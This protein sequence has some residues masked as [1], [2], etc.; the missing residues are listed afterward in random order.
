MDADAASNVGESIAVAGE[1]AVDDRRAPRTEDAAATAASGTVIAGERAV[2]HRQRP[3]VEDTTAGVETG[4]AA[5][6]AAD[7]REGPAAMVNAAT[8]AGKV[9]TNGA[10][11]HSQAARLAVNAAPIVVRG[12]TGVAKTVSDGQSSDGDTDGTGDAEH[13]IGGVRVVA[14]DRNPDRQG[15]AVNGQVLVEQ[16]LAAGEC[17]GLAGEGAIE[18][19]GVP[20]NRVA[21]GRAERARTTVGGAGDGVRR[22]LH[23]RRECQGEQEG[24]KDFGGE[25]KGNGVTCFHKSTNRLQTTAPAVALLIRAMP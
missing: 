17:D 1:R 7:K 6:A 13:A 10:V 11:A 23:P 24:E 18:V 22:R 15:R 14:V 8:Q 3:V 20:R 5:Q 9:A 21:D 19:D 25:A 12:V 16:Q 2:A 4:V